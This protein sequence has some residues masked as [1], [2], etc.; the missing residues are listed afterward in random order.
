VD[1]QVPS[2]S[3]LDANILFNLFIIFS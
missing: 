1:S 2:M 3:R